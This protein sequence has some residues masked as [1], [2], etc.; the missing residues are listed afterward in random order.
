[1]Q[2]LKL[3][4]VKFSM[5]FKAFYN[6]FD[7]NQN[8]RIIFAGDF[9]IF[10]TSKPDTRGGKPVPKRKPIIKLFDIKESLDI[11]NILR[12]RNLKRQN[13]TFRQN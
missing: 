3:N 1:M 12:I 8:K 7:I 13:F 11:C 9:K 4:N 6:F 5:I 2:I 10:F